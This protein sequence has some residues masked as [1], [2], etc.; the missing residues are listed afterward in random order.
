MKISK[1]IVG[2]GTIA[3]AIA[4]SSAFASIAPY[5]SYA[6]WEAAAV[7][8]GG[9]YI[10]PGA[11]TGAG[12]VYGWA[13]GV[14]S[15]T[16]SGTVSSDD[17][18]YAGIS[19]TASGPVLTATTNG[20]TLTITGSGVSSVTFTL[21]PTAVRAF[22]FFISTVSPTTGVSFQVNGAASPTYSATPSVG[23]FIGLVNT[24]GSI[25]TVTMSVSSGQS[26]TLS[27]AAFYLVPAP[28]AVALLGAAGLV[29]TRRR[30]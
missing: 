11:G 5:S 15:T 20:G 25:Q 26:I 12:G 19:F 21:D 18:W 3:A 24:G 23:G 9:G 28:G 16:T 22:G 27:G 29:S 2:L 17:F 4:G 8:I 30:R 14:N 10:I 6:T 7:G 13:N 1:N